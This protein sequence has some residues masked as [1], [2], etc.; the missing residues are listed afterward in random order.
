MFNVNYVLTVFKTFF[1]ILALVQCDTS[2]KPMILVLSNNNYLKNI[3]KRANSRTKGLTQK[4]TAAHLIHKNKMI[5]ITN[6]MKDRVLSTDYLYSEMKR[7]QNTHI[8]KDKLREMVSFLEQPDN[9]ALRKV[10]LKYYWRQ[11]ISL[12]KAKIKD[13]WRFKTN[14]LVINYLKDPFNY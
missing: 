6:F 1:Q 7:I 11:R 5:E 4:P 3:Q 12:Q 14:D 2:E 9:M 10:V 8:I 13:P